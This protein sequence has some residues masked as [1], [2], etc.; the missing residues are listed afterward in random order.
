MQHV[1]V[2]FNGRDSSLEQSHRAKR[3]C[4]ASRHQIIILIHRARERERK[5]KREKEWR[6]GNIS[7]FR[8][9]H[10]RHPFPK[11]AETPEHHVPIYASRFPP[12]GG[13]TRTIIR[14]QIPRVRDVKNKAQRVPRSASKS[15]SGQ[16]SL[17]LRDLG[18]WI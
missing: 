1:Q 14:V 13:D 3:V 4:M 6:I 8:L 15:I 9:P 2:R 12:A 11:Q 5:K 7:N 10:T 17:P 18:C 16:I